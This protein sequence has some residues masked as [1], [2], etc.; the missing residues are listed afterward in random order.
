MKT[1][2]IT[3]I[4][5]AG[6]AAYYVA[7][8]SP[9]QDYEPLVL[10]DVEP[11]LYV[12]K[13]IPGPIPAGY[14]VTEIMVDGPCCTGCTGKLYNALLGVPGVEKASVLFDPEGTLAK[15]LVPAGFEA[16]PLESSLTFEKYSVRSTA[17]G[18]RGADI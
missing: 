3:L 16:A 14:Q 8:S 10:E 18:Q 11:E 6:A 17:V 12:P 7:Q 4:L 15:A 9:D 5:A 13:A 1:G 2:L